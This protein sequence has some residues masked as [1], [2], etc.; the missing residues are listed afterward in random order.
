MLFVQNRNNQ[1]ITW[2]LILYGCIFAGTFN[3]TSKLIQKGGGKGP[4]K[5]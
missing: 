2:T 4:V 1:K 5:P 3:K